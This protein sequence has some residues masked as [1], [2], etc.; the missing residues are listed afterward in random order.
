MVIRLQKY[1]QTVH[2]ALSMLSDEPLND[3]ETL[4]VPLQPKN[5][6]R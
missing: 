2:S 4:E 3:L 1:D 6:R 5:Q